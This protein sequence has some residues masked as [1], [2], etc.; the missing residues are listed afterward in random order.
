MYICICIYLHGHTYSNLKRGLFCSTQALQIPSA[1]E[2]FSLSIASPHPENASPGS[3]T[4]W[5]FPK[6]RPLN[7]DPKIVGLLL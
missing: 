1:P 5:E 6:I 7:I 2:D 3:A 4:S